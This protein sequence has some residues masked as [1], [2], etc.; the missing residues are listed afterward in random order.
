MTFYDGTAFPPEYRGSAF[1]ALH[2]SWNRAL[3]TGYKVVRIPM[4]NGVP[5]GEYQDFLTG[6]V[7]GDGTVWGRPVGVATGAD[8][9]LYVSEDENG[10][11]WRIA[12]Q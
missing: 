9:V 2:G 4:R 10:T 1:V 5:T 3:R 6:F 7:V 8:G 12:A 11:I